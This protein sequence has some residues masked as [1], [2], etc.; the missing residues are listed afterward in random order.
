MDE[1]GA[2]LDTYLDGELATEEQRGLQTHLRQCP[3]CTEQLLTRT[4]FRRAVRAAG[5][6]YAAPAELRARVLGGSRA[7]PRLVRWWGFALAGVAC[8]FLAALLLGAMLGQRVAGG[9]PIVSE[10]V[11]AHVAT[12]ASTTPVDVVSTDRHTVKPWFQGKV[13]FTFNLPE[14]AN[15]NY[16]LVGGRVTYLRQMPGAHLIFAVR[17]HQISVFIFQ[18]RPETGR[19]AAP[20]SRLSFNV[21]TWNEGGLRYYV[22]GDASREDLNGLAELLKATGRG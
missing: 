3:D 20:L 7:Q 2:K 21:T 12:L 22:V 11:D 13:P 6:R 18:D 9:N 1:W 16:T 14:L 4:Q 10:L 17:K 15:S 5:K 19:G 8:G